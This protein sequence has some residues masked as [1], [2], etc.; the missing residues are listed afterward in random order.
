MG[1]LGVIKG[2]RWRKK[3]KILIYN[4][5][6]IPDDGKYQKMA[7]GFDG[8]SG[9]EEYIFPTVQQDIEMLLMLV[10]V[11]SSGQCYVETLSVMMKIFYKCTFNCS[12]N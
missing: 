8:W 2:M 1:V 4:F 11:E 6:A 9:M 3:V 10:W 12:S 7:I 5:R